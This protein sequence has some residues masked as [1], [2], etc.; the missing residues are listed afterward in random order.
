MQK[1]LIV[2]EHWLSFL[3]L[4]Q[5]QSSVIQAYLLAGN[6]QSEKAIPSEILR[7]LSEHE[8][9]FLVEKNLQI[10]GQ[11]ALL[12]QSTQDLSSASPAD[13]K[14]HRLWC[15]RAFL[16]GFA[17][18]RLGKTTESDRWFNLLPE[19]FRPRIDTELAL[20]KLN[21]GELIEAENIF[22]E[23]HRKSH[24]SLDPYSQ[25]TLLGGLCLAL[26][27]KG[28]FQEAEQKLKMRR[29][30]LKTHL[31]PT[32]EFGT[33]L[34]EILLLLER[35]DFSAAS[36]QL[37][38]LMQDQGEESINGFFLSHLKLR[39]HLARNEL[40]EA[41]LILENFKSYVKLQKIPPGVLDFQLEE[42]EWNLRSRNPDQA[43]V[44]IAAL[45]SAQA[46]Q[47]HYLNFRLSLLKAQTHYLKG[48]FSAAYNEISTILPEAEKRRYLPALT[49]ALFHS[50]GIALAAGHPVQAKLCI[51]RGERLASELGLQARFA[52]FS[53]IAEVMEH[54]QTSGRALLSLVRRQEIGPELE[55]YLGTYSL[56]A[57][58]TL[59]VSSR[60]GQE[61]LAE[62]ELRRQLFLE[63]GLFWFQK[64]QILLSHQAGE[65]MRLADLTQRSGQ[66]AT[67][68]LFWNAFQNQDRGCTLAEIHQTR[69]LSTYREELHAGAAK[70]QISRLREMLR[71]CGITIEYDRD[72]ARY[73]FH[74]LLSPFTLLSREGSE[75]FS[76]PQRSREEELLSRIAAEP[77][78]PTRILCH[79]FKVSR[80]AL[81]PFLRKLVDSKKIRMVKRG[82]VSGYIFI[83]ATRG[84]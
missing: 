48:N 14:T 69:H 34:Y 61:T 75:N 5:K 72:L 16:K 25:C 65:R 55:Y 18:S 58:V 30:I 26:I 67:F 76:P 70:M 45:E 81:H 51:H 11:P 71:P 78:V 2:K 21:L 79:E 31:S 54:K 23:A 19:D 77:F 32:L 20:R 38:G 66:L 33:R 10:L 46:H 1:N 52:C 56:L 63:P 74:S 80:Q 28:S 22:K 62:S 29:R 44:G 84:R 4:T 68:K 27:Q 59:A 37:S 41:K 9:A 6:I 50:A 57:D 40:H 82:P 8:A 3:P 17:L 64:E 53:Y 49:W 47:N 60:R 15:E 42:I 43:F 12:L 7:K 73:S 36:L 39:L 13:A 35:N 24:G 83:N